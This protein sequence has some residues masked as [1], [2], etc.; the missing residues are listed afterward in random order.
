LI[1]RKEGANIMR[2]KN[3]IQIDLDMGPAPER[4]NPERMGR[5]VLEIRTSKGYNGGTIETRA[6]VMW[7]GDHSRQHCFGMSKPATPKD[8]DWS[9]KLQTVPCKRVTAKAVAEAHKAAEPLF[10]QAL[11]AATAFYAQV[12]S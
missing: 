3:T 11:A 4:F 5:R 8:G 6:S 7:I 1:K 2:D 9:A 10:A 12:E